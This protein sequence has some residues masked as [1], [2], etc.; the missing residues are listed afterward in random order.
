MSNRFAPV[1]RVLSLTLAAVVVYQLVLLITRGDALAP[2]NLP[3]LFASR[4]G[5]AAPGNPTVP[6]NSPPPPAAQLAT[7]PLALQARVERIRDSE[8][9]GPVVRPLPMALL[10]IAGRDAFIRAPSGQTGLL[11]EG[12]ALAG[13]KVLRIG[14]MWSDGLGT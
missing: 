13:V 11:R 5:S 10:G 8:V 1:F 2:M 9:F 6:T 4:N 3:D 12:E 14:R 7:L